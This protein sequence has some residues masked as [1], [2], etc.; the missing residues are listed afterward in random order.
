[1]E[2][3]IARVDNSIQNFE[4]TYSTS[5]R[6]ISIIG[7]SDIAHVDTKIDSLV[8]AN[9]YDYHLNLDMNTIIEARENGDLALISSDTLRQSIYTLSTLNETI[10]ER[11]RITNED[12][13]SLFIPYLNKNFNWRNL[14]FS[15]FSEQGFGKSKLYK[16]DNYKMLY[17]QEFE[18][19]LQGRIQYNKGN[20]QIYNAIKQQLKNIYLLL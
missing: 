17:D 2:N 10:K 15:L 20:L 14:G 16:N 18:N 5:K 3:N 11:E 7:S 12:L 1:M 19:H 9:N 4:S 6:L 8:F 13:M